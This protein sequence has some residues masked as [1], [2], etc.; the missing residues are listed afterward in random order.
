MRQTFKLFGVASAIASLFVFTTCTIGLGSIVDTREPELSIS[1]PPESSVIREAFVLS[2]TCSDDIQVASVKV[3]IKN[4]NTNKTY[5]PFD[6]EIQDETWKITLNN[7]GDFNG[8]EYPDGRYSIEAWAVDTSKR[9]SGITSRTFDIDNTAPVLYLSKPLSKGSD[10]EITSFGKQF[11]ISGEISDLHTTETLNVSF[12]EYDS[13]LGQL[14]EEPI[15]ISITGGIEISPDVPLMIARYYTSADASGDERKTIMRENYLKLFPDA[16]ENSDP[17]DKIFYCTFE[18]KDNARIFQTPGDTGT[19]EG[20]VSTRYFINS[21]DFTNAL[22]SENAYRLSAGNMTKFLNGTSTYTNAQKKTIA[23]TIEAHPEFFVDV[24]NLDLNASKFVMNPKNNPTF[25]VEGYEITSLAGRTGLSSGAGFP[26]EIN[27]GKDSILIKAKTLTVSVESD[28]LDGSGKPV[29]T[30]TYIY[31]LDDG[32]APE[33]SE[34]WNT[35]DETILRK[36]VTVNK[37]DG[38]SDGQTYRIKI[39]GEDRDG[40]PIIPE[41]GESKGYGF[42]LNSSATPP[43]VVIDENLKG[44]YYSATKIKNEGLTIPVKVTIDGVDFIDGD[45]L[46]LDNSIRIQSTSNNSGMGVIRNE[47]HDELTGLATKNSVAVNTAVLKVAKP[48]TYTKDGNTYSFDLKFGGDANSVNFGADKGVFKYS[49][50]V[51]AIDGNNTSGSD[52]FTFYIDNEDPSFG[53]NSVSLS[54]SDVHLVEKSGDALNKWINGTVYVKAKVHDNYG[55][56]DV[57]Y[58]VYAKGATSGETLVLGGTEGISRGSGE[59]TTISVDTTNAAFAPTGSGASKE[60]KKLKIKFKGIDSVGNEKEFSTD[61][62]NTFIDQE[63]DKPVIEGGNFVLDFTADMLGKD[64]SDVSKNI[65]G[66]ASNLIGKIT[67]DDGLAEGTKIVISKGGKEISS[68]ALDDSESFTVKLPAASGLYTVTLEAVDTTYAGASSANQAYRKNTKSTVIAIDQSVPVLTET[69]VNTEDVKYFKDS[70]VKFLCNVSDDL[71]LPQTDFLKVSVTKNGTADASLSRSITEKEGDAY[72]YEFDVDAAAEAKYVFEF[73]ATDLAGKSTTVTRTICKDTTPPVFATSSADKPKIVTEGKLVDGSTWYS[74]QTLNVKGHV[75]D[76]ASGVESVSYSI[77]GGKTWK[78]FSGTTSFEE[79]ISGIKNGTTIQLKAIDEA[80]NATAVTSL[81]PVLIDNVKPTIA[82]SQYTDDDPSSASASWKD[83]EGDIVSNGKKALTFRGLANDLPD[84]ENISGASGVAKVNIKCGSNDFSSPDFV[85]TSFTNGADG[86][87]AWSATVSGAKLDSAFKTSGSGK[88]WAQVVDKAGSSWEAPIASIKYDAQYPEAKI[89]SVVYYGTESAVT[90]ANKKIVVKGTASDNQ[91]L[92]SVKLQCAEKGTSSWTDIATL[93]SELFT[94]SIEVDTEDAKFTDGKTYVFR[95][96]AEDESGNEGNSNESVSGTAIKTTGDYVREIKIN[97]DSDRPVIKISNLEFAGSNTI[98]TMTADQSKH[99]HLYNSNRIY[100]TVSDDDGQPTVDYKLG[101]EWKNGTTSYY[102]LKAAPAPGDILYKESGCLTAAKAEDNSALK[103]A[104]F[105]AKSGSTPASLT[106]AGSTKKYEFTESWTPISGDSFDIR[107]DGPQTVIFRV[108]DAQ[109]A[110][111]VSSELSGTTETGPKLQNLEG[112]SPSSKDTRLFIDV[113]MSGPEINE[114]RTQFASANNGVYGE[115]KENQSEVIFGGVYTK[116]KMS[117]WVKDANGVESVKLSHESGAEYTATCVDPSHADGESHEWII[118]D[119]DVSHITTGRNQFV[120]RLTD[121]TSNV[122]ES[123][124]NIDVDNTAPNLG[125]ESHRENELISTAFILK[126]YVTE[127]NKDITIKYCT[128]K[129]AATPADWSTADEV[130]HNSG[131]FRLYVDGRTSADDGAT[132]TKSHKELFVDAYGSSEKIEL[133]DEK[134]VVYSQAVGSNKKGDKYLSPKTLWFHFL[135]TDKAGNPNYLNFPLEIDPQGDIPTI[136]ITYPVYPKAGTVSDID[137][138]SG[139]VRAQGKAAVKGS[140]RIVGVYIQID[141]NVSTGSPSFNAGKWEGSSLAEVQNKVLGP[142]GN[143]ISDV[144]PASNKI[145]NI[146]Q[147]Y[148][149]TV[150]A[151]NQKVSNMYAIYVGDSEA[152]NYALNTAKELE[153]DGTNTIGVRMYVVDTSGTI[154][155]AKPENDVFITLDADAPQIGTDISLY[156]WQY[157]W[158]NAGQKYY[159]KTANPATGEQLYTDPGCRT[160]ASGKT[161]SASY[162]QD[163]VSEEYS[164]GMS[165][166]GEWWLRGSATDSNGIKSLKILTPEDPING[167]D[168]LTTNTASSKKA[169]SITDNG[170]VIRTGYEFTYRVGSNAADEARK[171]EYTIYAQENTDTGNESRYPISVSFDNKPPVLNKADGYFN[172]SSDVINNYGFYTLS[173]SAYETGVQSGFD[174]V[175]VYFKRPTSNT[176]F[177]TYLAKSIAQNGLLYDGAGKVLSEEDNLYWK[178]GT[179]AAAG[180]NGSTVTITAADINIHKGGLVKLGGSYYVIKNYDESTKKLTLDGN[181]AESLAGS[182]IYFAIGNVVDTVGSESTGT[183]IRSDASKPGYGYYSNALDNTDDY[184]IESTITSN[185]RTVWTASINSNNISDGPIEIHYVVFD[186]AGNFV[187]DKIDAVVKNNN[188]RLASL[189]VWCDFDGNGIE[190]ADGS[191]SET[192]YYQKKERYETLGVPMS[193]ATGLTEN[194]VVSGNNKDADNGGT[195][196]MTVKNKVTFIPEII[197]GNNELYYEYEWKSGSTVKKSG[198]SATSFGTGHDDNID[199]IADNSGYLRKDVYGD[200]YVRGSTKYVNSLGKTVE[201]SIPVTVT[202]L[203]SIGNSVT[204]G[205]NIVPT[206][207]NYTIYDSTEGCNAWTASDRTKGRHTATFKVALNVQYIDTKAPVVGIKKFYWNSKTDN[208]LY[209]N[210]SD[211]GHIELEGDIAETAISTTTTNATTP[212]ALGNDP[213]VSGKI[214]IRGTAEDD[215]GLASLSV[216]FP[217]LSGTVSISRATVAATYADGV[218]TSV[219]PDTPENMESNGWTFTVTKNENT[220][221]GHKIEWECN[222]DTSY[223]SGVAKLDRVFTLTATDARGKNG[224]N[225]GLTASQTYQMDVVPY[226]KKITTSLTKEQNG[227]YARTA[228]G[229]YSVYN[230]ETVT[231]SGFNFAKANTDITLGIGSRASG[232]YSYYKSNIPVLNNLNKDVEYN[233]QPNGVT[234]NLLNDD[235]YFDVWEIKNKAV[236]PMDNYILNMSMAVNQQSGMVNFAFNNGAYNWSMAKGTASSYEKLYANTDGSD[237]TRCSSFTVDANGNTYGGVLWGGEGKP[238]SLFSSRW[239]GSSLSIGANSI[240][241]Q[242]DKDRY[243]GISYASLVNASSTTNL[244]MAFMDNIQGGIYLKYGVMQG[245]SPTANGTFTSDMDQYITS[246]I[247]ICEPTESSE[248]LSVG[249]TQNNTVVVVWY[250]G[251]KLMYKFG[252]FSYNATKETLTPPTSWTTVSDLALKA[253]KFCALAVDNADGIHIAYSDTFKN[254]LKYIYLSNVN[255]NAAGVVKKIAT[256]DS[257]LTVGQNI[258]IDVAQTKING[259]NYQ[260]PYIGYF[261]ATPQRPRY[262]Y[263]ADPQKFYGT[264]NIDGTIADKYT[265]VWECKVIPSASTI[266]IDDN[267]PWNVNVG[268]WKNKDTLKKN[269]SGVLTNSTTGTAAGGNTGKV[270][271]NGTTNAVVSY[272]VNNPTNPAQNYGETAQLK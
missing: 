162:T 111:F 268:V 180:I 94:W 248:Y 21:L 123:Y 24:A 56:S 18:L 222:I 220:Q 183:E 65:F 269:N 153:G 109:G 64:P 191:E 246:A 39:T 104:S 174:K 38:L 228:L 189:R 163:F 9:K 194:L 243:Q 43:R 81:G 25:K 52:V 266:F 229:H 1:Y 202:E 70:K 209:K 138:F 263:I 58:W 60:Y 6:A 85:V 76:N 147:R 142:K 22:V 145:E 17:S 121:R 186:K 152:W 140:N 128:D 149:S 204:S 100:L 225:T 201:Y 2:G 165:I 259:T 126:G 240:P 223:V 28:E 127:N 137:K 116:F 230:N 71:G 5:G 190:K 20:N 156:L 179:V 131:I 219:S 252:Q 36:Q 47:I 31:N 205:T 258:T 256:V 79:S 135:V 184:M 96:I 48:T 238:Y 51:L 91:A 40:N 151:G 26:I 195:A 211:N 136:E 216:R 68:K 27:A 33:G 214:T 78:K 206:W 72:K 15:D 86:A 134:M 261:A 8:F 168:V 241:A 32:N 29:F 54:S 124:V 13:G 53:D 144:L 110:V 164:D 212:V 42:M 87:K 99:A 37:A 167:Y 270:Y 14:S 208:S 83:I 154:S 107:K 55:M 95:A 90:E 197:G 93:T 62:G 125:I 231:L 193:V 105:T 35:T 106:A 227:I 249:V 161:W 67:D 113:D 251:G 239:G 148:N 262:A 169:L 114:G 215:I 234:N 92:R 207:F 69:A 176:V 160:V 98:Q 75:S 171:L 235:I 102:T 49:L 66:S 108:T 61:F 182:K 254:D 117:V 63:T 226:I 170:T 77:D 88:I 166:K 272:L 233:M 3:R 177:D 129:T 232:E 199:E 218:W 158:T 157:R 12:K 210:S 271:G 185:G 187:H 97:Q 89:T 192:Y 146:Y 4:A 260:I 173:S 200:S 120:L 34:I 122:S 82:A 236:S 118:N 73:V 16:D 247:K 133:N 242:Q 150:A 221:E 19:G 203:E 84:S 119:I 7:E 103:V 41:N 217:D 44:K 30:K 198:A 101:N 59:D 112:K 224:T 141:P 244:Y 175:V 237:F 188:P 50:Y 139:M 80:G 178:E 255:P 143:K 267:T 159:S 115:L 130:I 253:G 265:G 23:D 213:K 172:I 245:T 45:E 74:S 46:T 181:P 155:I 10:A 250:D 257:Y 196:F 11:K 264:S 57:R 132:H